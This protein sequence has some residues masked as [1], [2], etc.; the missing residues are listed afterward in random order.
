MQLRIDGWALARD[1]L[2]AIRVFD[3]VRDLGN[4]ILG[5]MRQDVAGWRPEYPNAS[6]LGFDFS[7]H[8]PMGEPPSILRIEAETE[9]AHQ[10]ELTVP[11]ERIGD[12]SAPKPIGRREI[13][14]FCDEASLASDGQLSVIGWAISVTGISGVSIFLN[15]K[16]I[17]ETEF[18]LPR[19]DVG[20]EDVT[21]PM[22]RHSGFRLDRAIPDLADDAKLCI[23][24]RNGIGD[25]NELQVAIRR[26]DVPT[27]AK[28]VIAHLTTKTEFRLEIDSPIISDGL[29]REPV[30][31]RL[32][33]SGWALCRAGVAG[34]E[35]MLDGQQLGGV[36]LASPAGCGPCVSRFAQYRPQR[37]YF[38]ADPACSAM[39]PT[40][41]S[42]ESEGER[43]MLRRVSVWRRFDRRY[44]GRDGN[45]SAY[46]QKRGGVL[47]QDIARSGVRP[48]FPIVLLGDGAADRQALR[49]TLD[50]LADQ[51][52]ADR[53]LLIVT[54]DAAAA[55][56]MRRVLA[57]F[58]INLIHRH[59]SAIR[60]RE[61]GR[62]L[63]LCRR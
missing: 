55:A 51:V 21:I 50:S 28:P 12:W 57:E 41:P 27:A 39:G 45:R 33:I 1:T 22:A 18:G 63:V 53:Q 60:R 52:A 13:T 6:E 59:R 48:V 9:V 14:L 62:R 3:G 16:Q 29:V 32:T 47:F 31:G 25:T 24:A 46:C 2:R 26:I 61:H 36:H 49:R 20:D 7:L 37:I 17:G 8:L 23:N 10:L 38:I 44:V 34:I 30:G 35:I 54:P 5:R 15:G 56:E 4:A 58:P 43:G 19:H 11:L 42:C 40:R